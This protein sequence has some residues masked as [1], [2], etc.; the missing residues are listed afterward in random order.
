MCQ[1]LKIGIV[2][3]LSGEEVTGM[4]NRLYHSLFRRQF[5]GVM[6]QTVAVWC[7]RLGH[8][9]TYTT[10]HGQKR[11]DL[12]VPDDCDLVFVSAFTEASALSYVLAKLFRRRRARTVLGG[13]HARAFP[14]DALRFFDLVVVDCDESTIADIAAGIYDPG[15]IVSNNNRGFEI[16]PLE[17]RCRD[18]AKASG[19]FGRCSPISVVPLLSSTGCPYACDF[20]VDWN[21]D[22]RARAT[23]DLSA[24]LLFAAEK[25]PGQLIAFYDP[26]FGVNFDKTLSAFEQ[27]S[28]RIRNPYI[29]ESSL[30]ILKAQRLSRLRDT[31]CVYIAPG[32][33]SWA[34][35]ANKS[36]TGQSRGH[37]KL[38]K[39]VEHFE[40]IAQFVP[41]LQANF[42]FGTDADRSY[43]PVELT[44]HFI[45]RFPNVFPGL[46][47][48]IA[49]GG[50]PMRESLKSQ[51]R[52]VDLPPIFYFNPVMT[53]RP[54]NY[55]PITFYKLLIELF[56]TTVSPAMLKKR[57]TAK[58]PWKIKLSFVLRTMDLAAY[59]RDLRQFAQLLQSERSFHD[60]HEGKAGKIPDYYQHRLDRR[61]GVFSELLAGKEREHY[62]A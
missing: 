41:G 3:L 45:E 57:M 32:V 10:Y 51:R 2:E 39:V 7:R 17:E 22:F 52:L 14:Q 44:K 13:P 24:D 25:F 18:V 1:K 20:C 33:E 49:F 19:Y 56:E 34:D 61:L 26:N 46:A 40:L 16:P 53:A 5:H 48:P 36:A 12:L 31:N 28:P 6:A 55:D 27:I 21:N 62:L 15:T 60:F 58:V 43:E 47:I 30:S 50:T 38:K 54:K 35:Y 11:P 29:V 9:V 8:E 59:L 4:S 37:E 42:L 23:S